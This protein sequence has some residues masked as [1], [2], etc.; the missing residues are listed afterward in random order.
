MNQPTTETTPTAGTPPA[1]ERGRPYTP[2]R[3]AAM[4]SPA[5][6]ETAARARRRREPLGRAE[7][8]FT[9]LLAALLG[10]VI[11]G[12]VAIGGQLI[13]MQSQMREEIGGLRDEIHGL[14][15]EMHEEISGL[16]NELHQEISGLRD[17]MRTAIGNLSE[18][19][20]RIETFLQ[21]HH[22][23]LPGP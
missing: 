8:I 20:T 11:V 3:G 6:M 5:A 4:R 2:V 12:F 14:R 23:P 18:R 9:T 17:E 1:A 7:R 19:M 16:R 10:S 21:I 13:S 15:S 22:G